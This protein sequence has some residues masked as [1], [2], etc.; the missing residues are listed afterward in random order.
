MVRACKGDGM[1]KLKEVDMKGTDVAIAAI[2]CATVMVS[3][4]HRH[5]SYNACLEKIGDAKVC[6]RVLENWC[7]CGDGG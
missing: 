4:F 1:T 6:E 3:V 7:A 5:K 2:I